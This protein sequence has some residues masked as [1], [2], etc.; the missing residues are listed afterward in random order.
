M[1]ISAALRGKSMELNRQVHTDTLRAQNN[2]AL[3][4]ALNGEGQR[5]CKRNLDKDQGRLLMAE[6]AQNRLNKMGKL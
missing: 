1:T 2:K 5:K 3:N 4:P 6:R